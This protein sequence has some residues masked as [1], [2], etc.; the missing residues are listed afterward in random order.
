MGDSFRFAD[1]R[2]SDHSW[3]HEALGNP[4]V[5]V[6]LTPK[7]GV[8]DLGLSAPSKAEGIVHGVYFADGSVCG[9]TGKS[10]KS[11]YDG[12]IESARKH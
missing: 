12:A 1:G 9:E 8:F 3:R 4:S 10:V 11:H 6:R 5:S 2:Y 7:E